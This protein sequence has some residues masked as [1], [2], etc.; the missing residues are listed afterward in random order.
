[1]K[2]R[3]FLK[4]AAAALVVIPQLGQAND[5]VTL[6]AEFTR[7]KALRPGDT[8]GVITPST[9]VIDP[10]RL[11]VVERTMKYFKLRW[12]MGRNVGRRSV[13]Y[14]SF[15]DERLDDLHTMFRDPEVKAVFALRG[16]YG[17]PHLLD[18]IDYDLIRRNP[19]IFLGFSDITALHLAIH[20]RTGLVTF[21]G[22]NVASGFSNYTQQHFRR[23]LFETTP[24][25]R[26]TNP[27]E[28]NEL[29]PNHALR[30]I[31]PGTATGPLVG[32]NLSLIAA[33]MGTPY[34][35]ETRGKIFF[36]E[37]VGEEP[38]RVDR[39]LTHL[40]LAGKFDQAAG[41]IFGECAGCSPGDYKPSTASPYTLGEVLDNILGAL[42]IPVLSGLTIGHTLDQLTLP[43]GVM[44]TLDAS[45]GTLEIKEAG[46]A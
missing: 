30:T 9:P 32:G 25:G 26:V 41:V 10:D 27:P 24:P 28:T 46:V 39:M 21:H 2:R 19:K 38:Y 16:G 29:R 34:E 12:K 17:A 6:P 37:D 5:A 13:D 40:R 18:R 1:M 23:A 36:I 20:K 14:K 8:V 4:S 43:L 33:T 31:R 35:I 44:A 22:P 7:P 11:A 45:Q 42:K 3:N 15:V